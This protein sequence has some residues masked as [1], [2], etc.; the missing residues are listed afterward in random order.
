MNPRGGNS[1]FV[2]KCLLENASLGD[3]AETCAVSEIMLVVAAHCEAPCNFTQLDAFA[4]VAGGRSQDGPQT[5]TRRDDLGSRFLPSHQSAVIC[6]L[7]W[8]GSMSLLTYS[9]YLYLYTVVLKS[10]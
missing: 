6:Y 5:V 2:Q 8:A 10:G 7:L 4:T 1:G 3:C 9:R